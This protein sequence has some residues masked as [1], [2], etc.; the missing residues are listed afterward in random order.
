MLEEGR[1]QVPGLHAGQRALGK[2][3]SNKDEDRPGRKEYFLNA[4]E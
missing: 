3:A 2:D 4:C 1:F